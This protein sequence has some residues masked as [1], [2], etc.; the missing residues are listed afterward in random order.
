M[1][2]ESL[3]YHICNLK[4]SEQPDGK[5][6]SFTRL[7]SMK[8]DPWLA[9][10]LK[11]FEMVAGKMNSFL[12]GFQTDVLMIP[13]MADT[14]GDLARNFLKRIILKDVLKKC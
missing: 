1:V 10:K 6:K 8:H 4:K 9:A 12:R 13:F 7:K 2:A 5:N 11:F 14:I 3:S